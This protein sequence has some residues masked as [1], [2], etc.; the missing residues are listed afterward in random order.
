MT[1]NAPRKVTVLAAF[2]VASIWLADWRWAVSVWAVA[3]IGLLA[4]VCAQ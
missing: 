2:V 3:A 1:E 4:A